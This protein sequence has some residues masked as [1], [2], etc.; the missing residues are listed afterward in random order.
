MTLLVTN[1]KDQGL[2]QSSVTPKLLNRF[3][4][5]FLTYESLVCEKETWHHPQ[6]PLDF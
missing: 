2:K 5:K 1:C 4:K 3:K 6:G